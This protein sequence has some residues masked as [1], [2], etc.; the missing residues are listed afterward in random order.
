MNP[1]NNELNHSDLTTNFHDLDT[2]CLHCRILRGVLGS[3]KRGS[4][5]LTCRAT[6]V[7]LLDTP[8][9][10]IILRAYPSRATS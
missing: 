7:H 2:G 1:R 5:I 9:V 6:A 8:S 3:I 4:K 10:C